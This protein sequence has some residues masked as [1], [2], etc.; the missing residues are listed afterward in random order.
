MVPAFLGQ[1]FQSFVG[2]SGKGKSGTLH[3]NAKPTERASIDC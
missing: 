2:T 1:N 3:N